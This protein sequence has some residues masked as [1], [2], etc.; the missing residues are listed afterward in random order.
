MQMSEWLRVC[1]Y[2]V[3]VTGC[4][5]AGCEGYR[6]QGVVSRVVYEV[7][8]LLAMISLMPLSNHLHVHFYSAILYIDTSNNA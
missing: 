4:K 1:H 2:K 6:K 3:Q 8:I 5:G 7:H